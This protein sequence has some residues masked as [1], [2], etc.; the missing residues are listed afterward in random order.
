MVDE[1]Q[2][3]M[4]RRTVMAGTA[5]LGL[6]AT[7][8]QAAMPTA[9]NA[10]DETFWRQIASDFDV[11][12][13]VTNLENGYWGVMARPVQEKAF[14]NTRL[15]NSQNSFYA[16][17]AY[18]DDYQKILADVAAHIGAAPDEIVLTRGATEALQ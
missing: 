11:T 18:K 14:E 2:M 13:D 7:G 5:A 8:S 9:S 1:N 12:P 16:R 4:S 17:R 3:K 6:S 15:V 10:S